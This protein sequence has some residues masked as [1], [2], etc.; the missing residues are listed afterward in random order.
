MA[1]FAKLDE[2]NIVTQVVAVA[3]DVPTS[4][5]PLGENNEHL[6]GEIWCVTFFKGGIWKQTS[7]N[8]S[9]RKQYAGKGYT[10]D[11]DKNIF[12]APQPYD[13]WNLDENSDWQPPADWKG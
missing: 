11:S 13:G 6:D 3:N 8:G 5:G 2:N 7:Y 10:Y 12:I 1:H 9:F 4:N